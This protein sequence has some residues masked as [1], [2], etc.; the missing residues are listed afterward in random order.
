MSPRTDRT[1]AAWVAALEELEQLAA[2]PVGVEGAGA[3]AGAAG[4]GAGAAGAGSARPLWQPPR[5]LGPLPAD[6]AE[7]AAAVVD[8]Q[9]GALARLEAAKAAVLRHLGVVRTV[10]ASHQPER[11]VYLDATG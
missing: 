5:D 9:R 8:V 4:A 7:R 3:G 1:H 2:E 11:P 10:E 6:L